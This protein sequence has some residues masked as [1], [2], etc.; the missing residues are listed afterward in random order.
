MKKLTQFEKFGV[1]AAIIIACTF[2]YMKKIYEPQEKQFKKTVAD[3][4]K[5]VGELGN[6]QVVS[7]VQIRGELDTAKNKKEELDAQLANSTVRSGTPQE[8]TRML[9]A[10]NGLVANS[11]L[12]I[13]SQKPTGLVLDEMLQLSWSRYQLELS[14]PYPGFLHLLESLTD[15]PD[16]IKIDD[17]KLEKADNNLVNITFNLLI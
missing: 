2:F 14:G 17:V 7:M 15:L 12:S 5:I 1:L 10:I 13:L 16:A 11:G 8:V 3:L 9:S 4:N 6:A